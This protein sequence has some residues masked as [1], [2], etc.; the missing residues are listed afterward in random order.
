M[1]DLFHIQIICISSVLCGSF[2][3]RTV[4]NLAQYAAALYQLAFPQDDIIFP[5]VILALSS[6]VV[7]CSSLDLMIEVNFPRRHGRVEQD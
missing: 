5:R 1:V 7:I 2:A 6:L 3:G 4:A